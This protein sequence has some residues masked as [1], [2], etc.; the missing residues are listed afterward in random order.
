MRTKKSCLCMV[1]FLTMLFSLVPFRPVVHAD[2]PDVPNVQISPEGVLTW[3]MPEEG[4]LLNEIHITGILNTISLTTDNEQACVVDIA[5]KLKSNGADKGNKRVTL[6]IFKKVDDQKE[7]VTNEWLGYYY[8]QPEHGAISTPKNFRFDNGTLCW[9]P[10]TSDG[11][12][13][14]N[15]TYSVEIEGYEVGGKSIGT[16]YTKVNEPQVTIG[17]FKRE[18]TFEF[19]FRIAPSAYGYPKG[20]KGVTGRYQYTWTCP[21]LTGLTVDKCGKVS[22]DPVRGATDYSL[23]IEISGKNLSSSS[24]SRTEIDIAKF[25][26]DDELE[27]GDIVITVQAG[28]AGLKVSYP[29]S[30]TYNYIEYPLTLLGQKVTSFMDIDCLLYDGKGYIQYEPKSQSLYFYDFDFNRYCKYV[31]EQTNETVKTPDCFAISSENLMVVGTAKN[32]MSLFV[33]IGSE[34]DLYFWRSDISA[35]SY[36]SNTFLADK[37]RFSNSTIYARAFETRTACFGESSIVIED[38]C[39]SVYL[40]SGTGAAIYCNKGKISL[41]NAR[42]KKPEKATVG[43]HS[44]YEE[45]GRAASIVEFVKNTPT[46]TPSNTPTATPTPKKD[47]HPTGV[48]PHPTGTTPHPTGVTPHPTG[49]TPHPTG[50][51]LHPTGTTPHPTGVTPHPTGSTPH[52]TGVTPHPTGVT[53]HP[54]G[55]TPHPTGSTPKPDPEKEPSIADFVER[56]Y[57]IA[58]NRPSEPEGKAFWVN[59]IESGNRTGGDCAHFFLIEAP[60]FLNRGL[61]EEDFV[62]TLYRTFF[63]R[64]SEPA[65]KKFWVDS[66]KSGKRTKEN[67][68]MGFIDSTEWCNVCAMYGVKSGAPNAKAEFASKNA[69]KFA[70]RLYTECLGRAPEEG[71]LKYW[72]L[73]L[74]NLEQTGCS[75]AK[76]FFTSDEF[77]NFKLKDDEYVRRLYT[78]FMGR[79]PEA[80]EVAY[81][82]SE[83]KAGRQTKDSVM[84]FFG[85]SEEFTNI[86][87]Q[88]GIDRGSI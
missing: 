71:G 38:G 68:I 2:L 36:Y 79:D 4:W 48:T 66:L 50:V 72:S 81:W 42:V 75:A 82:V 18:G 23:N 34:K 14:E 43:P 24:T 67:V 47:P 28:F 55:T 11:S 53:P 3:G 62:E 86:C 58:L 37:I 49:V 1:L 60:E 51:T 73:A 84:A 27:T 83:I 85:Q 76:L 40:E 77:V 29:A 22:W 46:P 20:E 25:F 26:E 31:Q 45:D 70:T 57:T 69:I 12:I 10:V 33:V 21:E 15:V 5:D 32:L 8:Y 6:Q 56:L 39:P 35:L 64:A 88:Y 41:S 65:G 59:E 61:N 19:V 44:V 9:D 63:D 16:L 30:C 78:T 74:T 13:I 17:G 54:T 80:S 52:P 87:K 7:P